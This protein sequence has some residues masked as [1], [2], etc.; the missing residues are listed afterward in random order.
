M[1]TYRGYGGMIDLYDDHLV[2][3]REGK[4]AWAAGLGGTREIPL[5]AIANVTLK[6]ATRMINGYLQFQLGDDH[7]RDHQGDLNSVLFRHKYQAEFAEL[8]ELLQRRIAENRE[9][10]ID[11]TSVEVDRGTSRLDGLRAKS[12]AQKD[13]AGSGGDGSFTEGF[14]LGGMLAKWLRRRRQ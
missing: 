3:R 11:P 6:P 10:G 14:V 9:A 8:A 1:K 13:A 12:A 5:A 4:M 7:P 2:V